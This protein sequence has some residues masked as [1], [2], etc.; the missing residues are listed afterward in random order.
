MY[1]WGMI[2]SKLISIHKRH[3]Y[4]A[5]YSYP[6]GMNTGLHWD[7]VITILSF[8]DDCNLSNTG[9]KH[10]EVKDIL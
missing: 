5:L 3:G 2:A 8:V 7:L 4:S 1:V 10:E 6:N 9:A